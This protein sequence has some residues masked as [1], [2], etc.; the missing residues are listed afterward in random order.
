MNH[1]FDC[2]PVTA[3]ILMASLE[4]QYNHDHWWILHKE[5]Y[6]KT[7]NQESGPTVHLIECV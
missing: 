7:E 4:L 3:E 1:F 2:L 6:H 5:S